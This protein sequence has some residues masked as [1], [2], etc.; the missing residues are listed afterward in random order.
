MRAGHRAESLAERRRAEWDATYATWE[1]AY[2]HRWR[3][4]LTDEERRRAVS[5]KREI[6]AALDESAAKRTSEAE[7]TRLLVRWTL[8]A[9]PF[10]EIQHGLVGV[11]GWGAAAQADYEREAAE[12]GRAACPG[13]GSCGQ[14][15]WCAVGVARSGAGSGAGSGAAA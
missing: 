9:T 8:A 3:T 15:G 7:W 13:D 4:D 6:L 11:A 10:G 12:R 2:H 5:I 1:R 14:H